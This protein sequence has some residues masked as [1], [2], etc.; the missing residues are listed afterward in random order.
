M[1]LNSETIMNLKLQAALENFL[2][3][4]NLSTPAERI[5]AFDKIEK[6]FRFAVKSNLIRLVREN[7]L[8]TSKTIPKKENQMTN[9]TLPEFI[10]FPK[11]SRLSREVI[12][13]EKID[14]TNAQIHITPDGQFFVGSRSRWITPEQDNYGFARWAFD[15]RDELIKLGPGRHFGEWWGGGIQRGYGLAKD[16]KRWSLF[17]T[18]RWCPHGLPPQQIQSADPRIVKFQDVL[19]ECCSLVLVLYR[20]VFQTSVCEGLLTALK[21][22]GS[23]AAPGFMRPE[24]IVV[25]HT[26][27]NIAFKKTIEKDEMPKSIA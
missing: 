9:Q 27:A 4:L 3:E 24:G 22:E 21:N 16:D 13:T 2:F 15:R 17:N 18:V 8:K 26:A 11:I 6:D 5:E 14:G 7:V 1:F 10:E 20:G 19:P 25:F 23:K 12:I